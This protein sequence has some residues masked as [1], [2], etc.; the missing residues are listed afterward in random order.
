MTLHKTLSALA[1]ANRQKIL[2]ILKDGEM[3]VSEILE[4]MDITMA[5]LSHHLDILR[6]AGL[7]SSRRQGRQI[8]YSLNLSVMEEIGKELVRFFRVKQ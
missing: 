4:Q 7:V 8:L 2:D 5:T 3:S 1:D 6:R